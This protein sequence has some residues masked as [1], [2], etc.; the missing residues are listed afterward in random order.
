MAVERFSLGLEDAEMESPQAHHAEE[1]LQDAQMTPTGTL[2]VQIAV[3]AFST[4]VFNGGG[5]KHVALTTH[6]LHTF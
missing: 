6:A 4:L 5:C 2:G 3:F 1:P